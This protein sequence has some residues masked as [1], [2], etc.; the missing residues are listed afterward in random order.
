MKSSLILK[1]IGIVEAGGIQ[2]SGS[3]VILYLY[4]VEV[5]GDIG[6]PAQ[7]GKTSSHLSAA[8]WKIPVFLNAFTEITGSWPSELFHSLTQ[9]RFKHH[10]VLGWRAAGAWSLP[11]EEHSIHSVTKLFGIHQQ[12]FQADIDVSLASLALAICCFDDTAV[13]S[14]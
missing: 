12:F 2:L 9:R 10:C 5:D 14:E 11:E 4:K 6:V 7:K 13:E 1:S 3:Y 8:C